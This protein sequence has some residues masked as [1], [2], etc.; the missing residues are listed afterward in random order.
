MATFKIK[1]DKNKNRV[2]VNTLD[3]THKKIM[4]DF[5]K[6][7]QALPRKKKKLEVLELQLEEIEKLNPNQYSTHDIKKRAD[8]KAEIGSIKSEIYDI[9]NDVS[10]L[11]YYYK[12]EDIIMDYYGIIESGDN[13]LYEQHPEL[14]EIKNTD[15]LEKEIDTLDKL[16]MKSLENKKKTKISKKRK[17]IKQTTNVSILSYM[18]QTEKIDISEAE[19]ETE[20]ETEV[21]TESEKPS[22]SPIN[23]SITNNRSKLFDQYM[24][25]VDK[26]YLCDKKRE[27]VIKTCEECN[28]EKTLIHAEGMYVCRMCGQAEPVIVDSEKPNY[29]EAV[30]DSK[31]P[32]P[33]KKLNHLSSTLLYFFHFLQNS[34][35]LDISLFKKIIL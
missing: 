6:R 8:L 34:K 25:L 17:R 33:Y 21:E 5:E 20:V 19:T 10:E 2:H 28:M 9:E 26:N 4:T 32:L 27:N 13:E 1:H 3:E 16:N 11:D 7:R 23:I 35:C 30:S 22:S 29:K 18:G 14:Q 24:S 15:G 31:P 12:T